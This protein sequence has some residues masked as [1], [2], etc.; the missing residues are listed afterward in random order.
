MVMIWQWG[1][2]KLAIPISVDTHNIM[3]SQINEKLNNSP[4][5][6]TYYEIAR[7][8]QEQGIQDAE[9][10]SLINKAIELGGD[11]Y[12]Y[13][14]VRSLILADLKEYDRAIKA[15]KFSRILA[16]KE[17][18]DEFVRMNDNNIRTWKTLKLKNQY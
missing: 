4:S 9:S 5:A 14:R 3:K 8:Y 16:D 7:Y 6:Q 13:H 17:G 2:T 1:N 10:L 12:Y 11:T 15:A 18:K